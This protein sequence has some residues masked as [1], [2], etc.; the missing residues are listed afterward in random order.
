[1]NFLPTEEQRLAVE[2]FD[3]FLDTRLA[4]IVRRHQPDKMI[5]KDFETGLAN[6]KELAEK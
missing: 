2:G 6:L 4:P 3:R 5:G 1:M